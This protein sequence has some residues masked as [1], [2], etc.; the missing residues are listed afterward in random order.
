M[1][2]TTFYGGT[3][4]AGTIF[5][6]DP[7]GNVFTSLF[8]FDGTNGKGPIGALTQDQNGILFGTT[9]YGGTN[10]AGTIFSFNPTGNV[11]TSL[12]SF[13]RTNSSCPFA[14]LT[15]DNNGIFFCTVLFGGTNNSYLGSFS[16]TILSTNGAG[17]IFPF[18]AKPSV[19]VLESQPL[20]ILGA[21]T[22]LGLG[23]GL[24]RKLG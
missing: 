11:F 3:N 7:T 21:I 13:G 1:F 5:S 16:V 10:D 14:G 12:A 8:S 2:G 6:F 17:T 15:Q 24:K 22:L 23:V 9:F 19:A 20:N 4:D 18:Q